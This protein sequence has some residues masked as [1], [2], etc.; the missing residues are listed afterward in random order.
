MRPY[1]SLQNDWTRNCK[2]PSCKGEGK[3]SARAIEKR[4]WK[5]NEPMD[6]RDFTTTPD[7]LTDAMLPP[8]DIG[9]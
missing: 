7:E 3:E 5:R 8:N 6:P 9:S 1:G 4:Y 2:C